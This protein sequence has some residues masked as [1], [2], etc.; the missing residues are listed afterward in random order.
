[1]KV[2]R[3][4]EHSEKFD[5]LAAEEP[6]EIRVLTYENSEWVKHRVAVTMRTPGND[7]ELSAGFL[8]SEGVARNR[9]DIVRISYCTDPEEIQRYNIVNV[10][11]SE[12]VLFDPQ[13]MSR[14]VYTSSSCGVCGKASLEQVRTV[15]NRLPVGTVK[16]S[17]KII[18]SLPSKLKDANEFHSLL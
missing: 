4:G 9:E 16:V 15:C 3:S 10:Y 13:Q 18:L 5:D 2:S 7:F 1:M 12:N 11:L 6:M 8:L 17:S 14:H